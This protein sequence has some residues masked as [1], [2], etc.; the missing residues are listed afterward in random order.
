MPYSSATNSLPEKSTTF[1]PT[2]ARCLAL[3]LKE[4]V[5]SSMVMHGA[6]FHYTGNADTARCDRCSLEVSG[7]TLDMKPFTV[8]AERSP[9]CPFV[10]RMLPGNIILVSSST[11]L[12][13]SG[14]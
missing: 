9:Q 3:F 5:Y 1:R 13:T 8:H 14:C 11:N 10:L 7:W 6:G 12:K 4:S 2:I